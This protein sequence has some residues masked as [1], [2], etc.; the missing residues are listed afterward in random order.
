[1]RDGAKS[2]SRY[3]SVAIA[4]HWLIAAFILFEI[5]LGWRTEG[6]RQ[7]D[8]FAAFQLHK[9]IGITILL[10]SLIRLGWRLVHRPPPLPPTMKT[11]ESRL[12]HLTH[13]GFYLIMIGLP[14]T[15]WLTVS[16]S[17]IAVPTLLYG[18][19][20]LPHIP[21]GAALR[22]GAN[23][24]AEF[25]HG[26]LVKITYLLLALH[27]AGA[28]KH[29]VVDRS[30]DAARMIPASARR[31]LG[32]LLGLAL[33]GAV[34]ALQLGNK[35]PMGGTPVPAATIPTPPVETPAEAVVEN[36]T[37]TVAAATENAAAAVAQP[38]ATSEPAKWIVAKS[39][40]SV[41]FATTWGGAPVT[42]KFQRWDADILFDPAAL[43][44]SSV[45]AT[46]DM[47]SAATGVSDTE[48]AL[49]GDDW[50]AAAAHPRAI[51]TA[52]EFR[53]RGGDRYEA[54]G[55]LSLRGVS[56]PLVLPFTLTIKGDE[57]RMAGA[58]TI[59]RIAFGV[60]QGQWSTTE[61][62]SGSVSV[63]VKIAA[64]RQ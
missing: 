18:A 17:R 15:G 56:R 50:F 34:V 9:S 31:S 48:S 27:I 24:A 52:K 25:G 21:V 47:T 46:I 4:L 37:E 63:E 2:T 14:L 49:P 20:P 29:H 12:A 54:R 45:K 23:S 6:P 55:T 19:I 59:D 44:R 62:V 1:M 16:T 32:L 33:V 28:L 60:G 36:R 42:G 11:W 22:D 8:S 64:K 26:A 57:A 39:G 41:G 40:S 10:L 38:E 5:G 35:L 7:P 30:N 3:S 43:D 53:S 51:F 58:A 13:I 61:A